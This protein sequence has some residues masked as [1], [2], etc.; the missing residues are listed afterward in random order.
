MTDRQAHVLR[1]YLTGLSE[2][3]VAYKL[4]IT[5]GTLGIHLNDIRKGLGLPTG[6]WVLVQWA[7]RTG[8]IT[9]ADFCGP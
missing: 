6:R 5:V 3:A 2:K 1:L 9:V 8:F 7:L 4:G